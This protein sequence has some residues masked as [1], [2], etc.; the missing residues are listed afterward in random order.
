MT[1][2]PR[3]AAGTRDYLP[4]EMISRQKM[5]DIV[6]AVFESFGFLPLDTPGL[7]LEEVLTGG[8]P[9]FSKQ[10]FMAGIRGSQEDKFALRFDLTVPLARVVAGSGDQIDRPFKR[11]Q[12]GK[13]WRGEKPQAGRFREFVQFDVDTIGSSRMAADAEII[14]IM[15]ETMTKLGFENFMIKVNNRKILNGLAEFAGFPPEK[16]PDVL[17]LI[18]KLDKVTRQDIAFSM[19]DELGITDAQIDLINSFLDLKSGSQ[20]ETLSGVASLMKNSPTAIEGVR[21]LQEITSQLISLGVPSDKWMI[22]LSVARGLGYYTGPV[23]ETVLTDM[24]Q[25]GSVFG[26]GRYDGLV[27]RFGGSSVPATGVSLGVDRIFVAMEKLGL[28]KKAKVTAKVMI[29]NF[30]PSC[31]VECTKLSTLI[32]SNGIPVEIYLGR[33]DTLKGQLSFAVKR[34]YPVVVIVGSKEKERGE[35]QIK[36]MNA[37]KQEQVVFANVPDVIKQILG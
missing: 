19:K 2:Q 11:Y 37:R 1:I 20:T 18:D 5:F 32:R 7:E 22:D 13:V 28:T 17:R 4:A 33:E 6:R 16:I 9:N 25:I 12:M 21:E 31:E 27:E 14:A 35:A 29:L 3:L 26:G 8:D 24:P 10:I 36:D 23:F 15:Y 34:E 30:D